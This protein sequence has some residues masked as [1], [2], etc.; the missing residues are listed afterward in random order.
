LVFL[1]VFDGIDVGVVGASA[2]QQ[3]ADKRH[4][5]AQQQCK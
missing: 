5:P 4:R 1:R 3:R 2:R